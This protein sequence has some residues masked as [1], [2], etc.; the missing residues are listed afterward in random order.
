MENMWSK[1]I[2]RTKMLTASALPGRRLDIRVR[3]VGRANDDA[4][5]ASSLFRRPF[6]AASVCG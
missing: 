1:N 2:D 6:P 3:R 5:F 4:T